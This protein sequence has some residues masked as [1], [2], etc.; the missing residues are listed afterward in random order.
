MNKFFISLTILI[1]FIIGTVYGVLFTKTGNGFISSYIENTVNDE[2]SDVKLKVKDFTLTFNT[3]NFDASINDDSNINISGDLQ[4]FKKKVDLKYDIKI[5]ELSNLENL[6][7]QKLNGP[8]STSGIFKGDA[9]FSEISGISDIAQSETS[10][11]LKLV[12]FEPKNIDFLIKNARIEKLLHLLNQKNLAIGN[13]T[14]KGDIKDA[15]IPS[16]D[17]D[18]T[19]NI[20]KGKL[21]NKVINE[22]FK[23]NIASAIYFKSDIKAK[24]TPNKAT[25]KSDLI[26]SLADAFTNQTEVFLDSGKILTDYKLDVKNLAKLE[27]I[28]GKKLYGNFITNGKVKVENNT[29]NIDGSS[30]IFE[31]LTKYSAKLVDSNPE[32]INLNIANAK[33]DK[34]LR[35][36]NEPVYADGILNIDANIVNANVGTLD[37]TI[38]TNILNGKIINPVANTVF[39]QNLKKEIVF[40]ANATTSLVPSQAITEAKIA[41]SLANIDVKKAVFDF[42]G[43]SLNSD[44]LLQIPSLANLYDITSTKLRGAINVAGNLESKNKSLLLAGNSKLLDGTLDFNLKNDDFHADIKDVQI[45][46]LTHMLYYP[47]VFDSTTA[48]TLDYNLLMKKGKLNGKLIKG[49]FL[50]NNFSSLLNQFAKFDITREVYESVDIETNINKL[51]LTSTINMK[52]ENTTIDI[53][54]SVLDLEKS[55]I[56]AKINTKIKSTQFALNVK[57]N[58]SKPKISLDSKDL[59]NNQINKQIEKNEEKIKEKLNKVLKGKL[60]EDGAKEV[61][62]NFKSLF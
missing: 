47:E 1:I 5:N 44:Y 36:L 11:A 40:S 51:V 53:N 33:I 58:T 10:Y 14:L 48:L 8:F 34:L 15:N 29:I 49:H 18:L 4:I 61:L 30:D 12:D 22:E 25:I 57:G 13:L 19:V 35:L 39:K 3:I 52:S 26:T 43:A 6:T 9:N 23:Q 31:S 32:F 17:G 27:G 62:K 54:K 56:D 60:G 16:L 7:K 45:K 55:T 20:S 2:Q 42:K 46:K 28:I 59:I 41:T 24:L 38:K 21:N 50:P 37:G